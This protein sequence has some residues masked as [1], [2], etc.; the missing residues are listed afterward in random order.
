MRCSHGRAQATSIGASG[1]CCATSKCSRL[2]RRSRYYRLDIARRFIQARQRCKAILAKRQKPCG[3][4]QQENRGDLRPKNPV[5]ALTN[6]SA[7][8]QTT[9]DVVAVA[10][11][12]ECRQLRISQGDQRQ[13]DEN[14][15]RFHELLQR[16]VVANGR[17]GNE[18]REA[19]IRKNFGLPMLTRHAFHGL[20]TFP[21]RNH[22]EL[23]AGIAEP[24]TGI[25]RH[26]AGMSV[27]ERDRH[28]ACDLHE[29]VDRSGLRLCAKEANNHDA[30]FYCMSDRAWPRACR[31]RSASCACS[32]DSSR[33]RA[34]D[35]SGSINSRAA[36]SARDAMVSARAAWRRTRSD[37]RRARI[38]SPI[39]S[40]SL[41][42]AQ[43]LAYARR[44]SLRCSSAW[45]AKPRFSR[46][47]S[48]S[49]SS[50]FSAPNTPAM[51]LRM[52]R[53]SLTYS[54][55]SKSSISTG[56]SARCK[57][58]FNFCLRSRTIRYQNIMRS[59]RRLSSHCD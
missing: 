14:D 39:V 32:S 34:A 43:T 41:R 13:S 51:F 2:A 45:F 19:R 18:L 11:A 46:M 58:A 50:R 3:L 35:V 48:N 36:M 7:L 8:E 31:P 47:R 30:T 42:C 16:L 49:N 6:D 37:S 57:S 1:R 23:I 59:Q 29:F 24:F 26:E 20:Q 25:S 53:I 56:S 9:N 54:A 21:H 38:S 27:D 15:N 44:S 22:H 17:F 52:R 55:S 33:A 28:L 12:N 40:S 10:D 5:C 4:R